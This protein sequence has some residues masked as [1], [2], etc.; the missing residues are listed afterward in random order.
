MVEHAEQQS[1]VSIRERTKVEKRSLTG[2]AQTTSTGRC[3]CVQWG[4]SVMTRTWFARKT[5]TFP[6][7]ACSCAL[8]TIRTASA[9]DATPILA[10]QSVNQPQ[11][12]SANAAK[13]GTVHHPER[14][15]RT[16]A[17]CPM[18]S[19]SA[20][21][22]LGITISGGGPCPNGPKN[23]AER[24]VMRLLAPLPEHSLI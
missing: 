11:K 18:K 3:R 24:V 13:I 6:G 2:F 8:S 1:Q 19:S 4:D 21:Q 23:R 15:S 16:N 17:S 7:S 5:R 9:L 20:P 10:Q 12:C 14:D 22:N